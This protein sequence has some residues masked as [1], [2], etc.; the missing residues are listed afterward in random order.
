MPVEL[1]CDRVMFER[2]GETVVDIG[3]VGA[4]FLV[5]VIG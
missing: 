4:P 5:A 3:R 2:R 1:V